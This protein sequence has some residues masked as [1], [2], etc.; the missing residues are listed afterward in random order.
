MTNPNLTSMDIVGIFMAV[1]T[2]AMT[3][4]LFE[5]VTGHEMVNAPGHGLH[6]EIWAGP[7]GP[8]RGGSGLDI[9]SAS[10]IIQGRIKVAT[11]RE[12]RDQVE[13]DMLYAV[14]RLISSY[15]DAFQLGLPGVRNIDVLGAYGPA[16]SAKPGY[17]T[18]DSNLY[19][20]ADIIIPVI[21]NDC[22]EQSP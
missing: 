16:L 10:V 5:T 22:W 19:R 4:G 12:P 2:H 17:I 21:V 15:T 1:Q 6:Y 11:A 9:T 8:I 18:Q 3:L 13:T 14:D 7:I 20:V